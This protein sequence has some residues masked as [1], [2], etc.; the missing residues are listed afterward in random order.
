MTTPDAPSPDA[1]VPEA[2]ALVAAASAAPEAPPRAVWALNTPEAPWCPKEWTAW[3]EAAAPGL[4]ARHDATAERHG[5]APLAEAVGSALRTE[6]WSLVLA[7]RRGRVHAHRGEHREDAGTLL[8]FSGGFVAAVADGAGSAPWSRLGSAIAT[9][10]VTHALREALHHGSAPAE[11]LSGALVTAAAQVN[12]A[13]RR[14]AEQAGLPHKALRC[15]LL[16]IAVH[17][18]QLG[19]LQV[20]DGAMALRR[21]DGTLVHPHAAA[22]GDFSGEVAHF[23]PDEGA[24]AV[25]QQSVAVYDAR[26][27]SAALLATDG[28]EDPWYPFTRHAGSLFDVLQHGSHSA[29]VLPAGL[30]LSWPDS[31]TA[32]PDPVHALAE[33]LA[34]EKRGENDD[35]TLCLIERVA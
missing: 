17:A 25:L 31:V 10:V 8:R 14:F 30:T 35:R 13:M 29:A 23:L 16:V 28:V 5:T 15:T 2:A 19:V 4:R 34:F 6:G 26:E 12:E 11:A 20:G 27:I 21:H 9:D 18:H 22:T 24:L 1:S 33:W 32:A 7:S 3:L